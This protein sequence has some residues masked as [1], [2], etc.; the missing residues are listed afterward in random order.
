[1]L[2]SSAAPPRYLVGNVTQLISIPLSLFSPRA[3]PPPPP[4]STSTALLN[5]RAS[6]GKEGQRKQRS[7]RKHTNLL[8]DIHPLKEQS[9]FH[10][11]FSS[12]PSPSVCFISHHRRPRNALSPFVSL[13]YL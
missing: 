8:A 11:F 6:K 13:Y 2:S 5:V 7:P 12:S 1:V 10:V 3:L 9:P 4:L